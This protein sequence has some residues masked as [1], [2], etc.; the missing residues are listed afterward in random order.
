MPASSSSRTR[1]VTG[2][3]SSATRDRVTAARLL[4]LVPGGPRVDVDAVTARVVGLVD[5]KRGQ[6]GADPGRQRGAALDLRPASPEVSWLVR[7]PGVEAADVVPDDQPVGRAGDQGRRHPDLKHGDQ[8]DLA[9]GR[10]DQGE[11]SS[12]EWTA[13]QLRSEPDGH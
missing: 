7:L 4:L 5:D 2:S 1:S 9:A 8:A 12:A 13:G 11:P 10:P 3:P 6:R